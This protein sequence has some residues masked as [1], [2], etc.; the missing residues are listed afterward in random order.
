MIDEICLNKNYGKTITRESDRAKIVLAIN[1]LII[2]GRM[3]YC[4]VD[5]VVSSVYFRWVG[6]LEKK[7]IERIL[8][9]IYLKKLT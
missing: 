2:V 5:I 4:M 1:N 7:I 6:G 3:N 8:L 9:I